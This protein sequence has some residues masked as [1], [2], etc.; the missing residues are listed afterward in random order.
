[1]NV[2]TRLI[3][4]ISFVIP[5]IASADYKPDW[6][7]KNFYEAVNT[8]RS[9][10]VFPAARD[11]EGAGLK[12]GRSKESLR[13]EVISITPLSEHIASATCY[14]ALNELA[15]DMGHS[16]FNDNQKSLA[17]YIETPRCKAKFTEAAKML[18]DKK[19]AS[20]LRLQ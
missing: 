9:A 2:S 5:S 17:S 13:S 3:L 15:K 8:C 10:I 16:E 18:K 19:A 1:V 4:A 12:A 20:A 11:Y 6:N 7:Y 14:C